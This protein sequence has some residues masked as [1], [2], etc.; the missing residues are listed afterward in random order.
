[1][2]RRFKFI[3]LI[4]II[5]V[6]AFGFEGCSSFEYLNNIFTG[7]GAVQEETE[8]TQTTETTL[9][10][11]TPSPTP[12]PLPSPTP[13]PTPEH[14]VVDFL[15]DL[16]LADDVSWS[17]SAGS[18][19]AV[20]NGDYTYCFQNCAEYLSEDDL[21]LANFEGVLTE[22]TSHQT[23]EFVFGNTPESVQL[24]LNGSIEAVN[25]ANNHSRD[26]WDQ[27][28]LDTEETL[29]EAGI[30][31]SNQSTVGIY[32]VRGIKIGMFGLD[33]VSY[34]SNMSTAAPLIDELKAQGCQI[35]IASCHWGIERYYEPTADQVYLGHQLIDY[36]VDIV[37]GSHPH[38]LQPIELYNGKYILYSLS[39]FCF[40]GNTGLSDPDSCIVR[41]EFIMDSTNSYVEDYKLSV[42]P[43]SQTTSSGNDYCPIAYEWGTADY[44][45]V[46]NKLSWSQEDE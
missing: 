39:N 32:E 41:C 21:T 6:A 23:K 10:T 16:T 44:Y 33:V 24:L 7:T 36:G 31:W 17:G 29:D 40:G 9:P 38:R 27:G 3:N 46:M 12:T 22:S 4:L 19:D 34:G 25:L 45:R 8:V 15:G 13:T 42:V 30:V 37:V 14:I 18:F 43:Y 1:V 2:T 26:Y 28:L 20:V 11:P 5:A 35:I